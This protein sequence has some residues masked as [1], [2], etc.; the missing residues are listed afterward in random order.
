MHLL[1]DATTALRR[2][3][4]DT[5]R[6]RAHFAGSAYGLGH[7]TGDAHLSSS[8][9]HAFRHTQRTFDSLE[10]CCQRLVRGLAAVADAY[11]ETD[12]SFHEP[13]S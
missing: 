10:A 5:R 7:E 2:A 1:D 4:D 3:V 6:A 13:G 8:Y 11:Q 12:P 9:E